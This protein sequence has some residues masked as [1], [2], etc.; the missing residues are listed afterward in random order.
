MPDF[1]QQT[2]TAFANVPGVGST[3]Q[4]PIGMVQFRPDPPS[5]F[6]V[7]ALLGSR[8]AKSNA[9]D[10]QIERV[11]IPGRTEL[12]IPKGRAAI[13]QQMPITLTGG[14][15]RLTVEGSIRNLDEM[16]GRGRAGSPQLL[17]QLIVDANGFVDYD[18]VWQPE[19]RWYIEGIEW[20][21]DPDEDVHRRNDGHRWFQRGTIQL[22]QVNRGDVAFEGT[23]AAKAVAQLKQDHRLTHTVVDGEDLKSIAKLYYKRTAAWEDIAR[24]N[25]LDSPE[26]KKGRVLRLPS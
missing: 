5:V 24:L 8:S 17:L 15:R 7:T 16:R 22:V 20:G 12:T 23:S 25:G 10:S 3:Q 19:L 14:V 21:D 9:G 1:L 13:T 26:V 4:V 2:G 18:A 11:A 6:P